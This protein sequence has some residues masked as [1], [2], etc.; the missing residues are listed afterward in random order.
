MMTISTEYYV[1]ITLSVTKNNIQCF[2]SQ[3]IDLKIGGAIIRAG[4]IIGTNTVFNNSIIGLLKF[5]NS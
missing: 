5:Q 1:Q 2:I 4:V 3:E